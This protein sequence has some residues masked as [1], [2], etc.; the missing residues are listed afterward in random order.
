MQTISDR[1]IF[2]LTSKLQEGTIDLDDVQGP[3]PQ[4]HNKMH[5]VTHQDE[6][7]ENNI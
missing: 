6:D 2:T 3:S 4:K 7:N 5:E 1:S